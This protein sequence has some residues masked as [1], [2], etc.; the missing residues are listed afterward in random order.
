MDIDLSGS[1]AYL[2]TRWCSSVASSPR[3]AAF[4]RV[5]TLELPG[6]AQFSLSSTAPKLCSNIERMTICSSSATYLDRDSDGAAIQTWIIAKCPSRFSFFRNGYFRNS[7]LS[8]FWTA[9]SRIRFLSIPN[10][11][12]ADPFPL[13]EEQ[14]PALRGLETSWAHSLPTARPLERIQLRLYP[15]S[16]E[17]PELSPLHSFSGTLTRLNILSP[18]IKY[19]LEQAL[20]QAVRELPRL[21]HLGIKEQHSDVYREPERMMQMDLCD[22]HFPIVALERL[23]SLASLVLYTY[24]VVEFTLDARNYTLETP[25]EVEALG[26]A[27]MARCPRMI[28]TGLGYFTV[29]TK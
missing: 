25:A 5:L 6:A 10:L 27:V 18:H 29:D 8:A 13:H 19:F 17:V 12:I 11:L 7:Y 16:L 20:P 21:V 26:R 9:Q 24:T 23:P 3:V 14:L 15:H 1:R 22:C 4:I 2:L 28:N